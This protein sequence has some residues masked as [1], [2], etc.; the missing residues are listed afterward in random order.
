VLLTVAA[1]ISRFKK[2]YFMNKFHS[3]WYLI[4]TKPRQEKKV[5]A[6]LSELKVTSFLPT[7]KILRTWHD[8]KKFVDEPLFPSYVFIYLNN[9]QSYYDGIDADGALYY[10][11]TG[12]EM[13]LVS[14]TVVNN[15]KLCT[16]Q[17]KEIEVTDNIF[18]PGRKLVV[19]QGALTGLTCE[20]IKYNSKEKLLVR[21]D[22]LQRGILLT[23]SEEYL[24]PA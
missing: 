20:M 11:K 16:D 10:V 21:V 24:M 2:K 8:R 6:R 13:A 1:A 5:H 23:I 14:D 3:G 22:L 12:K 9:M 15:I 4:Y 7:K 19:S 17:A 18:Q